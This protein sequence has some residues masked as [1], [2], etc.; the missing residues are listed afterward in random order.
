MSAISEKKQ[1]SIT[2]YPK[3]S[4]APIRTDQQSKI[5]FDNDY[6]IS[7]EPVKENESIYRRFLG[8]ELVI[9]QIL[10]ISSKDYTISVIPIPP[11]TMP[12]KISEHVMLKLKIPL[13][14]DSGG[15]LEKYTTM[16]IELAVIRKNDD[17]RLLPS[18][19]DTFSVGNPKY[20]LY[21]EPDNGLIARFHQIMLYDSLDRVPYSSNNFDQAKI[22]ISITN[23][24]ETPIK[25]NRIVLPA[26]QMNFFYDDDN[27]VYL[28]SLEMEIQSNL[29]AL[30]S[31]L[32]LSPY[33][34]ARPV[35][36]ISFQAEREKFEMKR[37]IF[38][39]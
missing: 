17:S 12:S 37:G 31:L 18:V 21:G 8:H 39:A 23:R 2:P 1:C 3:G 14:I 25:L 11:V 16:P 28:E 38:K 4:Y 30:I 15:Q 7:I 19:I 6:L 5:T 26:S 32:N 33:S 35:P 24:T 20:T 34:G 13:I 9:E 36:S 10:S 29:R 22:K 27:I